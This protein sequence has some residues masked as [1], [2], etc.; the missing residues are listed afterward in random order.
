MKHIDEILVQTEEESKRFRDAHQKEREV[1]FS[2]ESFLI[3]VLQVVAGGSLFA[4]L[5]QTSAIVTLAGELAFLG[6][7]TLIGVALV[8]AVLAAYFKHQY[9]MW[10][11]KGAAAARRDQK[12]AN[13]R[14]GLASRYLR[15][16]RWSMHA[17]VMS[18]AL[19]ILGLLAFS[20]VHA[21][22]TRLLNAVPHANAPFHSRA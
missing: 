12:E 10:D 8:G 19:G 21:W 5:A 3:G 22:Q 13:R 14:S 11:V 4:A 18:F 1:L 2:N 20:W 7:L 15:G 17:A 6:F 9:K 16:M